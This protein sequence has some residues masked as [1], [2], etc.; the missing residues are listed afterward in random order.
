MT[1]GE[2]WAAVPTDR[3]GD[4][5]WTA[6]RD[7]YD[8][9]ARV[10]VLDR[11]QQQWW[12]YYG[13]D[14]DGAGT[15]ERLIPAGEIGELT[16]VAIS[17]YRNLVQHSLAF[18]TQSRAAFAA[19]PRNSDAESL[20][21]ARIANKLINAELEDRGGE[22]ILRTAIESAINYG[23]GFVFSMWDDEGG[24]Q[25][26][27]PNGVPEHRFSFDDQGAVVEA[28]PVK[29]GE[30]Y[31][32]AAYPWEVARDTRVPVQR[33]D[34]PRKTRIGSPWKAVRRP[35]NR[36]ELAAEFPEQ[37]SAILAA[38]A[39]AYTDVG[40]TQYCSWSPWRSD[41]VLATTRDD[42][43][44]TWTFFHERTTALPQG[45]EVLIVD[46]GEVLYDRPLPYRYAPGERVC[47]AEWTCTALGYAPSTDLL[48]IQRA[49]N[50]ITSS[51]ITTIRAYATPPMITEAGSLPDNGGSELM[52]VKFL[53]INPGKQ[54]PQPMDVPKPP[55]HLFKAYELF[56]GAAEQISGIN[57][58][59]RGDPQANLKSGAAL[60][61]VQAQAVQYASGV[62]AAANDV[63]ERWAT[64]VLHLYQDHANT[65][66]VV[67]LAGETG[68][69][70]TQSLSSASLRRV[71]RIK[72]STVNPLTISSAGRADFV[73]ECQSRGLL[74]PGNEV[75]LS[76]VVK[77]L[78][79]GA[80][81]F[82]LESPVTQE[83]GIRR[84]NQLL[85]KGIVPPVLATDDHE[86]HIRWH[87][88]ILDDPWA[89]NNPL[90]VETATQHIDQHMSFMAAQAPPPT[91]PSGSTGVPASPEMASTSPMGDVPPAP[92]TNPQMPANLPSMPVN[93]ATGERA[94]APAGATVE[95]PIQ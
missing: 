66:R 59:V 47:P 93:P 81:D 52:G 69:Y 82:E 20:S 4:K 9:C 64:S 77:G 35:V 58:V 45:R 13:R 11:W 86:E 90:I 30:T 54:F 36:Y 28:I 46:P 23:E 63:A 42:L 73:W 72:M 40:Y 22:Q 27:G 88:T 71:A 95:G 3:I 91:G 87:K 62:V 17:H 49:L 1:R 78:S 74:Q 10:G 56:V 94:P 24:E 44:Y 61:L 21:E 37:E 67:Q 80:F 25:V 75:E 51:M 68:N 89:R 83:I 7:Y 57:S 34:R 41:G 76:R 84:E 79:T 18:A 38:P 70:D 55:E 31:H 16:R 26:V 32:F 53:E 15:A 14:A 48:G 19:Q 33:A 60:A 65:P 8:W 12:A 29:E 5:I 92:P 2:Y 85:M 6:T 50:G 39:I 43:I